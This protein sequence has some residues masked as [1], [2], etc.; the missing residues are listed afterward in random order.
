[1]SYFHLGADAMELDTPADATIAGRLRIVELERLCHDETV[2]KA[3]FKAGNVLIENGWQRWPAPSWDEPVI[4][5]M[6]GNKCVAGINWSKNEKQRSAEV[7]FA[8]CD[9]ESPQALVMCL[10]RA[11]RRAAEAGLVEVRF[12][13]HNG[14]EPMAKLVRKLRLQPHSLSFRVPVKRAA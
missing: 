14:N 1:M 3:A 11:R 9:S 13:H 7:E 2:S 6:D 5:V 12:A 4:A 10:L 8:F